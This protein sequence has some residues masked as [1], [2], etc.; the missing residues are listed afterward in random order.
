M[1]FRKTLS[2]LDRWAVHA[3]S[4]VTVRTPDSTI[5][6]LQQVTIAIQLDEQCHEA[7]G[8]LKHPLH[9]GSRRPCMSPALVLAHACGTPPLF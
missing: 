8:A 1:P 3:S 6:I 7:G 9:Y 4:T 5:R 2:S